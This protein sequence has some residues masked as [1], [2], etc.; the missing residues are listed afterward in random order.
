MGG[1][2]CRSWNERQKLSLE[3][4]IHALLRLFGRAAFEGGDTA[5]GM[6]PWTEL[7]TAC[8]L[9]LSLYEPSFTVLGAVNDAVD[10]GHALPH[11]RST[12]Q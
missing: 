4:P 3:T 10:T 5:C 6:R 2:F 11:V 7:S 12:L 8:V 1:L 9:I